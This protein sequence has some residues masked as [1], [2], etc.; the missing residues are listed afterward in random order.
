MYS[1]VLIFWYF[2]GDSYGDYYP[3]WSVGLVI[4]CVRRFPEDG[5]PVPKYVGVIS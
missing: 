3:K 1:G 5:Y 2:R 4:V